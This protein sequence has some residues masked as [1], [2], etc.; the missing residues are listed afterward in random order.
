MQRSW[1]KDTT[2]AVSGGKGTAVAFTGANQPIPKGAPDHKQSSQIGSSV[3]ILR[4]AVTHLGS[5]RPPLST[6]WG[7]IGRGSRKS[8]SALTWIAD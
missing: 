8:G 1:G 2:R 5:V 6:K 3:G 4:I 7:K